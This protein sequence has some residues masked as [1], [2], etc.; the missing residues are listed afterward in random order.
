MIRIIRCLV[1]WDGK[2]FGVGESFW[3]SGVR[4]GI[5]VSVAAACAR[6]AAMM[7]AR[8]STRFVSISGGVSSIV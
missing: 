2:V 8:V 1:M 4:V 6:A 5:S 3:V 7:A